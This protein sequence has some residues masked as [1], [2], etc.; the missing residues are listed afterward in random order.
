MNSQ[1]NYSHRNG[2]TEFYRFFFCIAILLFHAEKYIIGE[3]SFTNG[4]H[5]SLFSHGAMGCEF[6]FI[7]SGFLMAKSIY[8]KQSCNEVTQSAQEAVGE[9]FGF[10]KK[11]YTDFF[12]AH[13]IAF[14]IALL[15]L[16]VSRGY[17]VRG[18]VKYAFDSVPSFFLVQMTGVNYS[19]PNHV[20]WYISCMFIAIALLYPVC[21]KYYYQFTRYFSW[22]GA[23]IIIGYLIYTEGC[24]TGVTSWTGICYRSLLRALAEIALGTTA[25]ELSKYMA[26]RNWSSFQRLI[27]TIAE[28]FCFILTVLLLILTFPEKYEIYALASIF[29]LVTIA[30]SEVTYGSKL[31]NNRIFYFLGKLSL[32]IYLGQLSAVYIVNYFFV[33]Y[34]QKSMIVFTVLFAFAIAA[35]IY[36]GGQI[37]KKIL[38]RMRKLQKVL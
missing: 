9:W 21:R 5:V 29:L 32:P 7:V 36:A 35:I 23:A 28:L 2:K 19:S 25:F 13:S 16:A 3:P 20:E 11:K 18:F 37:I 33:S 30:F 26:K 8:K 31:F 15:T 22:L 14:V 12:P 4:V 24:L 27:L 34:S 6:F 1:P 10:I 17:G 38:Q